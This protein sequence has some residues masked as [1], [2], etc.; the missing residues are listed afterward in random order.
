MGAIKF[1][2]GTTADKPTLQAGEIYVDTDKKALTISLDGSEEIQAGELTH[3]KYVAILSQA[4][5]NKTSGTLTIGHDYKIMVYNADDDFTNV[6]AAS[7][8]ALVVFTATGTTPTHWAHSSRLVDLTTSAPTA[9]V[10]ENTIGAIVWS[11]DNVGRYFGTLRGVFTP[12]KTFKLLAP[13]S[14]EAG[15]SAAMIYD[16]DNIA[17]VTYDTHTYADTILNNQAIEIRVYA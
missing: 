15:S 3:K 4:V 17:I 11:Y 13:N 5:N 16:E 14:A 10:L 6:G 12:N 9:V 7:N 1:K 2:R 8:E